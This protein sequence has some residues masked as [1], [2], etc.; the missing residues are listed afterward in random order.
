[1]LTLPPLPPHLPSPPPRPHL[2]SPPLSPHLPPPMQY[3]RRCRRP[4]HNKRSCTADIATVTDRTVL[5]GLAD[6]TA[7][8]DVPWDPSPCADTPPPRPRAVPRTASRPA[9]RQWETPGVTRVATRPQTHARTSTGTRVSRS[10]D[11]CL[12]REFVGAGEFVGSSTARSSRSIM[13]SRAQA[14]HAREL[15][16][17][18]G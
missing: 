18:S 10:P 3:C 2:P 7:A 11:G 15:I 4:G 6:V 8:A 12:G 14:A 5:T 9:S 1:M 13:S 17:C 16:G